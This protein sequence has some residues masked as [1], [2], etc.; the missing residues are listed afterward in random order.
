MFPY[1]NA[2]PVIQDA[3]HPLWEAAEAGWPD[4]TVNQAWAEAIAHDNAHPR[5]ANSRNHPAFSKGY[6]KNEFAE[7]SAQDRPKL[8]EVKPRR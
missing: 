5:K 8:Q 1:Q 6:I 7:R 2:Y 4:H 3:D